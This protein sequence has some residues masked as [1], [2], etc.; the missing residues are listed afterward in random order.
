M[1]IMSTTPKKKPGRPSKRPKTPGA[2]RSGKT[3]NVT[4]PVE[5]FDALETFR[6]SG[7]F[8]LV[9]SDIIERFIETGLVAKGFWPPKG[10]SP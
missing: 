2:A 3:F 5:L 4:I 8:P 6:K 1:L 9:R 10:S 7:E